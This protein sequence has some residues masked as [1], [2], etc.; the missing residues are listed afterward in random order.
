MQKRYVQTL[1]KE[2]EETKYKRKVSSIFFGG[3]TPSILPA[4][5]IKEIMLAIKNKFT[6]TKNAEI[7]IECNPNSITEEKL[8]IYKNLGFNRISFGVQSLDDDVLKLI[9]RVHNRSEAL[10]VINLANIA[11]FTNINAD[12]LLGIKE[13][14]N[15]SRDI[16]ELKAAG[17]THISAYMLILEQGTPLEILAKQNKV[18]LLSDDESVAQYEEYLKVLRQNGFYRYEISNFALK[19]YKCK[20]NINYWECGEYLG[21]GVAAHSYI[22]GTR[23]SNTE[24]ILE[25]IESYNNKNF[26]KLTNQEKLEELIMLGLRTKRGVSLKK[27]EEL[28]YK[29]LEN[30]NALKMLSL[31]IIKLNSTHLYITSKNF[32][33]ANQIIL[34]LVE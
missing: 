2:I 23:Y 25:Y 27:L 14:K 5:D 12:L 29:V 9:G 33:I 28:G 11:G 19:G 21:F 10:Q 3:G 31:G 24:N 20:H 13:N 8:K 22:N 7:S 6:L 1:I 32:G 16:E 18:K 30:K 15:I 4:E 26:E 34:K 17:V